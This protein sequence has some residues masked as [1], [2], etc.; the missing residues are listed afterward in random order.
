MSSHKNQDA[1]AHYDSD[2]EPYILLG[3]YGDPINSLPATE[4]EKGQQTARARVGLQRIR[5]S[6][7]WE[8]P[9]PQIKAPRTGASPRKAA[10][11][12]KE[13]PPGAPPR[14]APP[15]GTPPG[16]VTTV[17]RSLGA[18]LSHIEPQQR[19]QHSSPIAQRVDGI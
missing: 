19:V 1:Y 12:I 17:D 5:E 13:A 7:V 10:P 11:P 6:G 4:E 14:K 8:R 15:P 2:E 16:S 18:D 9:P 3:A